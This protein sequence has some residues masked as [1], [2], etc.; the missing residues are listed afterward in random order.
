MTRATD[1]AYAPGGLRWCVR[2]FVSLVS[3]GL[4]SIGLVLTGTFVAP[5]ANAD[6]APKPIVTGWMPYWF[7]TPAKPQGINAA[8]ANADLFTEVSPFWYSA[9]VGGPNGVQVVL[10]PNFTNGAANEAWAMGQLRAAG[11]KVLPSIADGT[12]KGRMAA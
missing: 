10:N 3:V 12:G 9:T 5:P 4:V 7:T 6:P 1:D 8:V 11:L 2:V